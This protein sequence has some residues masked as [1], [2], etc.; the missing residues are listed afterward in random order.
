MKASEFIAATLLIAGAGSSFAAANPVNPLYHSPTALVIDRSGA[1]LYA[2]DK[3]AS[4]IVEMDLRGGKAT[5]NIP[6]PGHPTGIAFNLAED[7][8]YVTA[9]APA[10]SVYIVNLKDRKVESVLPVG[11]E[12][13]APV[14]S[15]DGSTLYVCNRFDNDVS[16]VDLNSIGLSTIA[17]KQKREVKRIPV[18]RQPIAAE[19]TADGKWL[20]VGNAEPA[21]RATDASVASAVSLIDTQRGEVAANIRL[22]NGGV[23][24]R[25][26][27][28]S[29]DNRFAF[30]SHV[31]ARNRVPATQLEEGWLAASAVT[32]IDLENRWRIGTFLLDQTHRGA[33]NPWGLAVTGD[34]RKLCVNLAGVH[35]MAI[36]ELPR[37]LEEL[38]KLRT[39]ATSTAGSQVLQVGYRA[40]GGQPDTDMTFLQPYLNRIHL[41]GSGP[42][43]IVIRGDRVYAGM[44]F[45]GTVEPVDLD[46]S[47]PT[48]DV[49]RLGSQPLESFA[50][51]GER[52]WVELGPYKRRNWKFKKYEEPVVFRSDASCHVDRA[53]PNSRRLCSV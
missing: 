49:L 29:P 28:V 14:L 9:E 4:Q 16:I 40:G 12:P 23:S 37:L 43:P 39:G 24:I 5:H 38:E 52:R 7:R 3:T 36:V 11:H 25:G 15:A 53:F 35:E 41:R 32:V 47:V 20:V 13:T 2:A 6:L 19:L 33:G 30:V 44:Y 42:R 10:N 46:S 34:G 26:V 22:P 8:L 27:A 17:L 1:H 31:L 48:P 45:T 50:R 21:G 18:V 51:R